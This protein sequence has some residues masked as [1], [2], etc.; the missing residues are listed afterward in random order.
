MEAALG[1]LRSLGSRIKDAAAHDIRGISKVDFDARPSKRVTGDA[2]AAG[3]MERSVWRHW[4][5]TLPV[6]QMCVS[7]MLVA[8]TLSVIL[9]AHHLLPQDGWKRAAPGRND[10]VAKGLGQLD[11][12]DAD[13]RRAAFDKEDVAACDMRALK[14]LLHTAKKVSGNAAAW[15]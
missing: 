2:A 12:R 1:P 7:V 8:S 11:C 15:R 5:I 10:A 3:R 6:K 4:V 13:A 14:S 9:V